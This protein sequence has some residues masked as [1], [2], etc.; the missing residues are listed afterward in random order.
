M[1][2]EQRCAVFFCAH[3]HRM[4]GMLGVSLWRCA[5]GRDLNAIDAAHSFTCIKEART[6]GALARVFTIF[7]QE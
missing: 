7:W 2:G 3:I 6:V 4:G 1:C 5:I